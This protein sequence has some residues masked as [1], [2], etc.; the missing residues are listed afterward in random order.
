MRQVEER[1]AALNVRFSILEGEVVKNITDFIKNNNVG[2]L[3]ADL[4]FG[5]TIAD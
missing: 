3:F 5:D 2:E 4:V 1:C